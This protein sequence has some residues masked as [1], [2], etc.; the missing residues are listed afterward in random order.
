MDIAYEMNRYG[1]SISG[2]YI[3]LPMNKE[4]YENFYNE[5]INAKELIVMNLIN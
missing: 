2:D 3:N 5:L 4:Q 1:D